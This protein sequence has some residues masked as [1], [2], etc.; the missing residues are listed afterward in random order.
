M[1][2]S[3]IERCTT[4]SELA[5]LTLSRFPGDVV[6]IGGGVG[7]T[8]KPLLEIA[9]K[10]GRKVI[11]V[12]PFETG[13]SQMPE[14]YG[15]PYN[16]LAFKRNTRDLQDHLILHQKSSLCETS[17]AFLK[18]PIAFAFVDGLQYK[19]AV[20][21]DLR[22]VSHAK[23]IVVDDYDRHTDI[24]QVENAVEEYLNASET[25][26]LITTLNSGRWAVIQ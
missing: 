19:G 12:D 10:H 15:K 2:V 18:R 6:E 1:Q 20:L 7:E 11:V 24:S 22:I 3:D 13:W 9:K 14:S 16:Y 8:T 23:L 21:N 26:S 5:D 4:V 17:E 25:A